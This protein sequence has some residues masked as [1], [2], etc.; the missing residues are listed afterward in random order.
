MKT[1]GQKIARKIRKLKMVDLEV[2]VSP[3][4]LANLRMR[5]GFNK[6]QASDSLIV[7]IAAREMSSITAHER[8]KEILN[9][10]DLKYGSKK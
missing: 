10:A 6:K 5:Y 7:E 9:T 1:V 4:I 2:K 3:V 8:L